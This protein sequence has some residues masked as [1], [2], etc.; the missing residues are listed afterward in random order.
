MELLLDLVWAIL[1]LVSLSV[2]WYRLR[3]RSR[4]S[5]PS[6]LTALV[7]VITVLIVIFP[8]ISVDD[9]FYPVMAS[10]E[11]S[12]RRIL[13]TSSALPHS[14]DV[15]ATA[16]LATVLLLQSSFALVRLHDRPLAGCIATVLESGH[17]PREGRSPPRY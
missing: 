11:D 14:Q 17:T 4:S 2:L 8:A 1:V 6:R 12:A 10:L 13:Q 15:A 5:G 9:D 3:Q 16:L 7:A